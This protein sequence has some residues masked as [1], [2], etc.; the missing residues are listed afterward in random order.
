MDLLL[1]G[2]VT[3]SGICFGFPVAAAVAA[4][5]SGRVCPQGMCTAAPLLGGAELLL[6]VALPGR[7]LSCPREHAFLIPF[8]PGVASL[9]H[10]TTDSSECGDT[11]CVLECWEPW[12]SAGSNWYCAPVDLWV[13]MGVYQWGS[14]HV[15]MQ[16]PSCPRVGCSLVWAGLAKWCHAV[17]A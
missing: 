11:L 6:V 8:V 7:Q 12:C 15:E 9:V 14:R 13:Y 3:A 5:D 2:G 4:V 10:Y 16:G 17:A 1:A